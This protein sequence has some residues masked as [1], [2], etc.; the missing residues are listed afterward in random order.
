MPVN[1]INDAKANIDPINSSVGFVTIRDNKGDR[2]PDT[3][4]FRPTIEEKDENGKVIAKEIVECTNRVGN[5]CTI[6][7]TVE[8]T[9]IDDDTAPSQTPY[10]FTSN[11]VISLNWKKSDADGLQAD[12]DSKVSQAEYD[13]EKNVYAA[14]T[15]GDDDYQFNDSSITSYS[16]TNTIKVQADVANTGEASLEIN[17]LGA[18]SLQKLQGGA[19]V[20]LET[21][22]IIANQIFW[23]TYNAALDIFQFDSSP[24]TAGVT[25]VQNTQKDYVAGE[26][27]AP[28]DPLFIEARVSYDVETDDVFYAYGGSNDSPT[29]G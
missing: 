15:T 4:P 27:L 17:A 18:K 29:S 13:A 23:A 20:T 8:A 2:F 9:A 26:T 14:S 12:I 6:T 5:V 25:A 1:T 10:S 3:F 19:F 24:A 16:S 21:G 7:R 28:G 11:A 22:D